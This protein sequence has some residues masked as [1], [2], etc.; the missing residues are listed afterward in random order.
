MPSCL[1]VSRIEMGIGMIPIREKRAASTNHILGDLQQVGA[2][3]ELAVLLDDSAQVESHDAAYPHRMFV[4]LKVTHIQKRFGVVHPWRYPHPHIH[5]FIHVQVHVSVRPCMN[6]S[7]VLISMPIQVY[8][9]MRTYIH[10]ACRMCRASQ[11]QQIIGCTH[12]C[13]RRYMCTPF[14]IFFNENTHTYRFKQPINLETCAWKV[15][16]DQLQ[17]DIHICI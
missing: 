13:I 12:I 7:K 2:P 4:E 17:V 5:P 8:I 15:H 14:L 9:C 1:F 3:A 11:L 6:R 16:S 10:S